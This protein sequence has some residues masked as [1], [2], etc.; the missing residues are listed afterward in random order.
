MKVPIFYTE[1]SS[2]CTGTHNYCICAFVQLGK[3]VKFFIANYMYVDL[4]AAMDELLVTY[5]LPLHQ[6][7]HCQYQ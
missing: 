7:Y 5:N 3:D 2:H 1:F 6:L 4:L